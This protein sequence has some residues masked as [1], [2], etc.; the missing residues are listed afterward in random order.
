MWLLLRRNKRGNSAEYLWEK[1]HNL[2]GNDPNC[3]I[4]S[5]VKLV[6]FG[7]FDGMRSESVIFWRKPPQSA[8]NLIA[9]MSV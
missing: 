5:V 8:L 9:K 7:E 3:V 1:L 4:F 6:P 2:R